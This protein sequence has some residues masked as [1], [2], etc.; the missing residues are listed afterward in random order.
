MRLIFDIRSFWHVGTGSGDFGSYDSRVAR[1]SRG[2]PFIPGRQV[3]GLCRQAVLDAES[4]GVP[5]V[6]KGAAT[7]LFGSRAAIDQPLLDDPNPGVL[8]FFDA[9]LPDVDRNALMDQKTLIDQLFRTRRSTA[10]TVDGVA[11]KHSLRFDEIVIPLTLEAI[12]TPLCGAPKK[13]DVT[14]TQA[15]PLLNA[16]GSWRTRGMGR[17]VVS[18]EV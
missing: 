2:L 7:Q 9:R 11:K 18:L 10:M 4:I 5:N 16:V 1:D 14:L 8:R 15:L 17:V 12:V 6:S 13:W 3:K